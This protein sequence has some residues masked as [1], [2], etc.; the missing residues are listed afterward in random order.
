MPAPE[1][2]SRLVLIVLLAALVL[3][4]S[5][6]AQLDVGGSLLDACKEIEKLRLKGDIPGAKKAASDC[7]EGLERE[8]DKSIGQYFLE[9]IAGWKRVRFE[10]NV[11]MGIRNANAEY[12]KDGVRV[13]VTFMS[14]GGGR[15]IGSA[16]SSFARMGIV[17]GG[18]QVTIAG[19]PANVL[20]DGT[21][22]VT[23]GD[24][25]SLNFES[26]AYQTAEESLAGMGDLIDKFP[27]ADM[28]KELDGS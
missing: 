15:G 28:R 26:S 27:V 18:R 16:I 11:A 6:S 24:D 13:R 9:E 23:F 8:T 21:V 22:L 12:E 19:L 2:R 25:S 20:P 14:G 5:A 17:G 4:A 7:L 3:P 1:R 10:Q